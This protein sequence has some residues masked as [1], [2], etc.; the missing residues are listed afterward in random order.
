MRPYS[1]AEVERARS[2]SSR[3]RGVRSERS[4]DGLERRAHL[5]DG[6]ERERDVVV[7]PRRGGLDH[8]VSEI[9]SRLAA[10]A[11]AAIALGST[12]GSIGG[13]LV[14]ATRRRPGAS[15]IS[16][17]KGLVGRRR[18][19]GVAGLVAGHDVEERGGVCDG[20]GQRRGRRQA[21]ERRERRR[22]HTTA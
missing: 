3:L 5:P 18:P 20:A 1:A 14:A 8:V 12:A 6:D 2:T 9:E 7:R 4:V 11:R 13:V 19:P 10:A 22:R 15:P 17:E 16:S 21:L